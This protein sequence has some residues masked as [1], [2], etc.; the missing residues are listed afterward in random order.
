[1]IN[2]IFNFDDELWYTTDDVLSEDWLKYLLDNGAFN[3][4][5]FKQSMEDFNKINKVKIEFILLLLQRG[6]IIINTSI[7]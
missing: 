6:S 7:L 5:A 3:L 4:D 1:M 2:E